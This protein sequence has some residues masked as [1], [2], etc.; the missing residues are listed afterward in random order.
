MSEAAG[1]SSFRSMHI[2]PTGWDSLPACFAISGI[3][4]QGQGV[5]MCAGGVRTTAAPAG[6]VIK[7]INGELPLTRQGDSA[8]YMKQGESV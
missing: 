1:R 8:V 2:S 5:G 3:H 7:C 6:L 4:Q